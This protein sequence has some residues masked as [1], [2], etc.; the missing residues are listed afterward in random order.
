MSGEFITFDEYSDKIREAG[1][2]S[3]KTTPLGG[4]WDFAQ[5]L[6]HQTILQFGSEGS[7]AIIHGI[8]RSNTHSLFVSAKHDDRIVFDGRIIKWPE[9]VVIPPLRHFAFESLGSAPWILFSVPTECSSGAISGNLKRFLATIKNSKALVVPR[10][11]DLME[12]ID[13]ATTARKRIQFARKREIDRQATET[14]LLGILDRIVSGSVSESLDKR[15]E[16][17]M[18]KVLE[19]LRRNNE[20]QVTTLAQAAGVS[21]RS[22]HRVFR[23]YFRMGP[24]R[25]LK[26]RQLNLVRHAVRQFHT[27][28]MNVTGILAEYGVTEFGRFAIEYRALFGESPFETLQRYLVPRSSESHVCDGV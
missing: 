5:H 20:I 12:L 10:A 1:A 17:I 8:T 25:Y 15:T 13:T 7:A 21:E 6:V 14:S 18:S 28:P 26:I 22:L 16:E 23:K 4:Q 24:K 9:I 11:A 19:R 27:A 3:F 2:L